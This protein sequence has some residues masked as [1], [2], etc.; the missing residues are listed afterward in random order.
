M[1]EVVLTID[2]GE[3]SAPLTR[4]VAA[5][6][7][8]ASSS[9]ITMSDNYTA[10]SSHGGFPVH[11]GLSRTGSSNTTGSSPQL[12]PMDYGLEPFSMLNDIFWGAESSVDPT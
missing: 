7:E 1:T 6:Q 8:L 4:S 5:L 12:S 11:P 10:N 9:T 3:M 2:P